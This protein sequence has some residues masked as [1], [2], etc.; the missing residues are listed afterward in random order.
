MKTLA[1]VI[2]R[3]AKDERCDSADGCS[4]IHISPG[5]RAGKTGRVA[6]GAE[7]LTQDRPWGW[8]PR[9]GSRAALEAA[10]CLSEDGVAVSMA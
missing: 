10:V 2:A 1:A 9:E 7:P 3:Y 5:P 8:N 6:R 4:I